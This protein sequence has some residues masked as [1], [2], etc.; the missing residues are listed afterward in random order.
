MDTIRTITDNDFKELDIIEEGMEYLKKDTALRYNQEKTRYD[1]LEP[2]AIE[3]LAKV[4]TKGAE[5]YEPY[6]WMKGMSWT[7]M[8]ASLKRHI[9][10]FEKGEDFDKESGLQHMAHAAWNAMGLV[11]YMKYRPEFDDRNHAYLRRPKI[12]LD[13]DE[14]LA[15]W[16]GH[17]T[18]H[19][20]QS[21]PE[22]WN[23]DRHI[24]D[25]F[26]LLKDNKDFWLSIPVKT[27]PSD[28]NFEPHCYIT[29]R[30]IPQEW[31]EQWLDMNGFPTM[32]VYT[33]PFNKSKIQVAK[34]SGID[35]FVDD[36]YENFVELNNAGICTFLFDQPHNRRYDVGY[37]RIYSLK[38]LI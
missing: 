6:N 21:V 10:A 33:V 18:K 5:K 38:D 11:T 25:K 20:G 4:F 8:L 12:G 32:P 29:S 19:H 37:K 35:W 22:T 23:F 28:I 16:V 26:E 2:Y 1:L 30:S 27:P 24:K 14:V 34:E 9:A 36:R 31:T 15:D 17:W 13:I 3:Q 7:A